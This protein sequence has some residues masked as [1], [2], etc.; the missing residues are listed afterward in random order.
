[1]NILEGRR[2]VLASQSPRRKQ[3]LTE[4]GFTFDVLPA[5]ID[6]SYPAD[7]PVEKVAEYIAHNKALEVLEKV[8]KADLVLAADSV[9]I[10]NGRIYGKPV[11]ADDAF[12]MLRDL[13]GHT[14]T[15]ITGVC[16]A[17]HYMVTQFSGI[18]KV[19][20]NPMTDAEINYYIQQHKPFDKAGSYGVQEWIGLC[21][22]SRIEGTYTNVMGLPVDLV[23]DAI[24][25]F[26]L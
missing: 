7:M 15:V 26:W 8:G 9:V 4:A 19:T 3:L 17:T 11:D 14:H 13:S 10:L 24:L 1:M 5:D 6:E 20:M 21:K 23:Y 25:G 16:L 22:I 12:Q 18:S 2:L